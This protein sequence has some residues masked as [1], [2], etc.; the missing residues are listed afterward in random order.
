MKK[1][2]TA[3]ILLLAGFLGGIQQA[4]AG[5]MDSAEDAAWAF[6]SGGTSYAACVTA[7]LVTTIRNLI[8]TIGRLLTNVR[9]NATQI[10]NAAVGV[11]RTGADEATQAVNSAQRDLANAAAQARQIATSQTM[12]VT[13]VPQAAALGATAPA[14][15]AKTATASAVAPRPGA[16]AAPGSLAPPAAAMG[17]VASLAADPAQIQSAL[18]GAAQKVGQLES[19]VSRDLVNR[20][21]GAAQRARQ[22]AESH[23]STAMDIARTLLEAPLVAIKSSLQDLLSH[24][25]RLFDPSATINAQIEIIS[26]NVVD[27]MNRINDDVTRDA[28]V[29]LSGIEADIGHAQGN[30][31]VAGNIV[32]AMNRLSREKTQPALNH[33]QSLLGTPASGLGTARPVLGVRPTVAFRLD[34]IRARVATNKTNAIAPMKRVTDD[35][36]SQ[37]ASIR[38]VQTRTR[39]T[40]LDARVQQQAQSELDRRF[41][42]KSPQEAQ[43]Q[44]AQ[45]LAQ[46]RQRFAKDP[47]VL[48]KIEQQLD[49]QI[50]VR[51][52]VAP[53]PAGMMPTARPTQAP[54][55]MG[56]GSVRPGTLAR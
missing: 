36:R 7:E 42:G 1:K 10:A 47:Q 22:Q 15:R 18:N 32:E 2:F 31:Q 45:L 16:L 14:L 38:T 56:D 11:V 30:A 33:L 8:D 28:L 29:T 26:N 3:A 4:I 41:K 27:A 39:P 44:K 55:H 6:L 21:T 5:C 24:P 35:I 43:Q 49:Q 40:T 17:P 19:D 34:T 13:Q 12:R 9:D 54:A 51:V 37:W 25:E 46:A 50:R 48:A 53:M 23:V 52:Q 20:V